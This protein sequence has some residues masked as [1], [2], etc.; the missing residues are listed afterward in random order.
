MLSRRIPVPQPP[1]QQPASALPLYLQRTSTTPVGTPPRPRSPQ[2]V[3]SRPGTPS[4]LP[5]TPGS[6]RNR[7]SGV[8]VRPQSPTVGTGSNTTIPLLLATPDATSDV[9]VDVIV[10]DIPRDLIVVENPFTISFQLT[11]SIPVLTL[12]QSGEQ[13]I[14]LV[15]QH[16]E[17]PPPPNFP[18]SVP[19]ATAD[20]FG[21]RLRSSEY[22]TPSP[23]PGPWR[24]GSFNFAAG[25]EKLQATSLQREQETDPTPLHTS[26]TRDISLPPPYETTKPKGT[27]TSG[28][29]LIGSTAIVL[30]PIRLSGPAEPK[31]HSGMEETGNEMASVEAV[32]DFELTF[33]PLE[34]G[35]VRMT[36]LRVFM[37]EDKTME[38]GDEGTA[39]G[40]GV[41]TL[42]EWDSIGEIWVGT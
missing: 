32:Q 16:I 26:Q 5:Q 35:F 17:P 9:E 4:A 29:A 8:P 36:G 21:S 33:L 22:S 38:S 30:P 34:K 40:K 31:A 10:R 3:Q 37:I 12:S 39:D 7:H 23:T 24:G 28:I 6:P 20:T 15:V 1:P 42:R 27:S 14:T 11:V 18:S 13:I 2:L 41:R 25:H 19:S